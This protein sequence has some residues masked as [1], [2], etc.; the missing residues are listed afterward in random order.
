M[1]FF[2]IKNTLEWKPVLF[3]ERQN[4]SSRTSV[5]EIDLVYSILRRHRCEMK[6]FSR[7]LFIVS[8]KLHVTKTF[9]CKLQT[10]RDFQ[11]VSNTW[12]NTTHKSTMKHNTN[13][14]VI[15]PSQQ[16]HHPFLQTQHLFIFLFFFFTPTNY[17]FFQRRAGSIIHRRLKEQFSPEKK[18]NNKS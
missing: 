4:R 5:F 8:Y 17:F 11:H 6:I 14:F 12:P 1:Y 15:T 2:I 9:Y 13:K 3:L 10:S 16:S 7:R 18:Q